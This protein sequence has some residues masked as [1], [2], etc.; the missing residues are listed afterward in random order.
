[1]GV[2]QGGGLQPAR[3]P[4]PQ[5]RIVFPLM[6]ITSSSSATNPAAVMTLE[7]ED[8]TQGTFLTLVCSVSTAQTA[9][10]LPIQIFRKEERKHFIR[11]TV[12]PGALIS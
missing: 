11:M 6:V 3:D 2:G 12:L 5:P 9:C 1:M 4:P 10:G 7:H 8:V